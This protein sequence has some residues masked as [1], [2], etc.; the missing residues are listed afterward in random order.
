MDFRSIDLGKL[1]S[2]TKYPSIPTY[3]ELLGKG[4]LGEVQVT[5]G[6]DFSVSEKVDGTNCRIIVGGLNKY[7]VGSRNELLGYNHDLLHNDAQGVFGAVEHVADYLSSKFGTGSGIHVYYGEVFGGKVGANAKQYSKNGAVGFRL[8]DVVL[9]GAA[10]LETM[11]LMSPCQISTWRE[12]GGQRFISKPLEEY[13]IPTVPTLDATAPPSGHKEC[14]EWLEST[15]PKTECA[16]DDS[17]MG[18]PEGVVVRNAD[19][20]KIAKI[21]YQDLRRAVRV[22]RKG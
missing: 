9:F 6:D 2:A 1:N 11:G 16:L 20:T 8:F 10:F 19:R 4:A 22:G 12:G 7:I 18:R 14:L 13:G 3:H 17:G 5:F 15:L 21:R